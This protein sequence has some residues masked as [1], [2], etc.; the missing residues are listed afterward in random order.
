MDDFRRYEVLREHGDDAH[1][2][3]RVGQADGLDVITLMRM[4]RKVCKLS[5]VGAKEVAGLRQ[6]FDQPQPVHVGALVFWDS[7]GSSGNKIR[8]GR[9]LSI[10]DDRVNIKV[11]EDYDRDTGETSPVLSEEEQDISASY[12]QLSLIDRMEQ[13]Q[14][15]WEDVNRQL[16][17]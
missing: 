11:T 8:T 1:S 16:Q 6:V 4:I 3:Y 17:G 7:S 15:F 10:E 9:V 12:F 5:L 13:T 14:K 2:I